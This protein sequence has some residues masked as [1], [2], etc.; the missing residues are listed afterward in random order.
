MTHDTPPS[1]A[2][3]RLRRPGRP[4]RTGWRR[5]VPTW[6]WTLGLS[7]G[8]LVLLL[9]AAFTCYALVHVPD[10]RA[11]AATAQSNVY[12]YADGTP[13]AR[14]G[15]YNRQDVPL[16][17]VPK[18][19]QEAVLAAEDRGFYHEPAI[20]PKAMLRAAWN[21]ATG[22]GTQSGSTITQQYVKNSYLAQDQTLTRKAK[23][24]IIAVKLSREQSKQNI[25][26]GYLNSSYFGRGAYGIQAAAQAYYGKNAGQL[27]TPEGAYLAALLNAPSALDVGSDPGARP[28]ALARWN[29]VLD[30]MVKE[31]WLPAA[32]RRSMT[33]PDPQPP[34]APAGLGG[35]LGYLVQA[36]RQYLVDHKVITSQELS[37]GGYRITTSIDPRRED[38]LVRSVQ[39]KVTSKLDPASTADRNVR[40]GAASI[41]P[42]SGKVVA[43][44]GGIDYTKQ[45]VNNATRHDF[46]PGSTFKP[47]LLASAIAN[48]SRTQ[49]G[50]LITPDTIYD[51]DNAR[52]VK[53]SSVPYA[54]ENEDQADYGPITV[55]KAMDDSVN[56]VFAQ[57]AVDVGPAKV[58][59]TA[60][61]AGIPA[62]LQGFGATPSIA[63]GVAQASVLDMTQAYAT[64]AA[65]GRYTPYTLVT[66]VTRNGTG[67]TLPD[68]TGVQAVPR[69][70][71]DTVTS[72]L[73]GTVAS[74]TA[75]A[76]QGSGR[77]AAAKTG[78]AEDDRA[79]L[80]AG[81]TPD[82]ATVVSVM[83]QDPDTGQ[84]KPLY[85]ALGQRRVNGGGP[86]GDVWAAY[87]KAA[88]AGTPP[89]SFELLPMPRTSSADPDAGGKGT[90]PGPSYRPRPSRTSAGLPSP[91]F[92]PPPPP[93]N[94]TTAPPQPGDGPSGSP[95]GPSNGPGGPGG[96]GGGPDKGPGTGPD[97]DPN[98]SLPGGNA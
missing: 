43:L 92:S 16:S 2:P 44:Y 77:E 26:Q 50:R 46:T 91:S 63:L 27:T 22:G 84:L 62:D 48:H 6:R 72:V 33:F 60:V 70:A 17:Q 10:S 45:Y 97:D 3:G 98:T 95:G 40:V 29:Y 71:A 8:F 15:E 74:G 83:G 49:D 94:R 76:A 1:P 86:P 53:G 78:T 56:S 54:P 68:R 88:L 25:L 85:G 9:G 66:S 14:T 65:H 39:D 73:R 4:R 89:V 75:R 96:P 7:L 64:L 11:A 34:K 81:Y 79:A 90:P 28:Q 18:Q 31:G 59:Q 57:M 20:D 47:L 58:K 80:F 21:M 12:L 67:L 5:F 30:G 37:H 82:L 32:E 23:E 41:D 93:V 61:A 87:T 51:G 35:Q 69:Q 36:V 42:A 55:S 24:I 19:V 52:P 13:L 38:D